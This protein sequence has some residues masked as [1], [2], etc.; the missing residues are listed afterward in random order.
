M[1]FNKYQEKQQL[2]TKVETP[3]HNIQIFPDHFI[4]YFWSLT[5]LSSAVSGATKI[6]SMSFNVTDYSK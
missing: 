4:Q 1:N 3:D 6:P 2:Q 5:E